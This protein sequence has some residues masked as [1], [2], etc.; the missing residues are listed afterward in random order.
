ML[1]VPQQTSPTPNQIPHPLTLTLPQQAGPTPNQIT[2]PLTLTV[3]QQTSPTPNQITHFRETQNF[4][5][6]ACNPPNLHL[7]GANPILA[8]P[9]L[10]CFH[11]AWLVPLQ[12]RLLTL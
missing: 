7:P 1:T 4:P 12:T 6:G 5:G 2:H 10:K 8:G 3:P 11:R 9:A